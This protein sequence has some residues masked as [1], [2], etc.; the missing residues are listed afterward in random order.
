MSFVLVIGFCPYAS[1]D[2]QVEPKVRS[3]WKYIAPKTQTSYK[4]IHKYTTPVSKVIKANKKFI[5]YANAAED[6]ALLG[7]LIPFKQARVASATIEAICHFSKKKYKNQNKYL[8]TLAKGSKKVNKA[9]F[10]WTDPYTLKYKIKYVSYY[11]CKG[12][13]ISKKKTRERSG[14]IEN[15]EFKIY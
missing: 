2:S 8:K 13:R 14:K 11:T 12:K 6:V 5:F 9:Y 7:A 4:V 15:G 3:E 10:K 1:A